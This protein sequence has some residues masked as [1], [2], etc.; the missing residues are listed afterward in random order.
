MSRPLACMM[1]VATARLRRNAAINCGRQG[2]RPE[3]QQIACGDDIHENKSLDVTA[4]AAQ[5]AT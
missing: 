5:D 3:K 1:S 4:R 2:R